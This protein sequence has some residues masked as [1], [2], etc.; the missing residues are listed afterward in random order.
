MRRQNSDIDF[1]RYSNKND[2][3]Y[4]RSPNES[5][6]GHRQDTYN[7]YGKDSTPGRYNEQN[8]NS[9]W[10]TPVEA[11]GFT[12]R[13]DAS[14]DS[15][16]GSGRYQDHDYR[17]N[18][19]DRSRDNGNRGN[20][21]Y[22]SRDQ[23]QSSYRSEGRSSVLRNMNQ[24]RNNYQNTNQNRGNYFDNN[25]NT[26]MRNR[27]S[28]PRER[29]TPIICYYCQKPGHTRPECRTRIYDENKN[30]NRDQVDRN[31]KV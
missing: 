2:G 22:G 29:T 25:R 15:E 10:N 20:S 8:R 17:P 12:R 26:M 3:I 24:A 18:Y 28:S 31:G 6:S 7:E 14:N 16:R 21:P 1:D 30:A 19:V 5:E 9:R 23:R 11:N 4:L 13:R 27:S